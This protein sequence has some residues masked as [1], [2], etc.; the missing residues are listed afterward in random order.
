MP[1]FPQ[2]RLK[3]G[4]IVLEG[5][6]KPI[7]IVVAAAG[8]IGLLVW[9]CCFRDRPRPN[10]I[11][12]TLD[13]L[14]ADHLGCYGYPSDTSPE[15]DAMAREGVLFQ[16]AFS[17]SSTTAPSHTSLFTSL[18]PVQHRVLKNGHVLNNVFS[19]LAEK[20]RQA[21]YRT[22][23]VASTH[24]H[25]WKSNLHQG[26]ESFNDPILTDVPADGIKAFLDEG[27]Y[28]R[29]DRN[30]DR[31][32]GELEK[33]DRD[34]PFFLWAHFFDPHEPLTPPA[35]YL[36][37]VTPASA[38]ER[39]AMARYLVEERHLDESLYP[40]GR[41]ELLEKVA[42]Y[43]AEIR[44]VD[45]ELGRMKRRI[46]EMG[47]EG[48][49]IWIITADHGEGLGSHSWLGHGRN[50]YNELINVPLIVHYSSG[51]N[52]G[53]SVDFVVQTVDILPTVLAL[54]GE[55]PGSQQYPMQGSSIIPLL[56]GSG[57]AD[58]PGTALAQRRHFSPRSLEEKA[59]KGRRFSL[60]DRRYKYIWWSAGQDEF[61]D[62]QKDP[63]ELS[64]LIDEPSSVKDRIK[65]TLLNKI[66]LLKKDV[67][68]QTRRMSQE[69]IEQLEQMGYNQ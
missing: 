42:A 22:V 15:I 62:L 36:E 3:E 5:K 45:A 26:F 11:L 61:Y 52:S 67:V 9:Y 68:I 49:T 39:E 28:R 16:G 8:L 7:L 30:V 38:A 10:I 57:E 69:S 13:T 24:Q 14:R 60:Q 44:F 19:T 56:D 33:L 29:A 17:C 63:F 40:G 47:F 48:E 54:A 51:R 21:D 59:E 46:E 6:T 2:G 64:N 53:R 27:G 35:G 1:L 58:L 18:Y 23:G 25:F 20:L 37:K 12:I 31:A 55:E 4:S 66:E 43:D 65:T 41:E 32:L 50:I 34:G